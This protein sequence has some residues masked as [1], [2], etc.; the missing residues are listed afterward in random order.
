M[1]QDEHR[2][3]FVVYGAIFAVAAPIYPVCSWADGYSALGKIDQ[4]LRQVATCLNFT[5]ILLS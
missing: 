1:E 2:R 5:L 4:I 3:S